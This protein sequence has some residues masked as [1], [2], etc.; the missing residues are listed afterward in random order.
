MKVAGRQT[1]RETVKVN[2]GAWVVP[3]AVT[4]KDFSALMELKGW[5][6]EFLAEQFKGKIEGP[7][8]FFQRMMVGKPNW[9]VI[10]PYRSVLV[11]YHEELAPFVREGKVRLCICGCGRRVYDRKDYASRSC[12][13]TGEGV[14]N[15]SGD[16][17]KGAVQGKSQK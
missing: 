8:K 6:P 14:T 17:K 7:L 13:R 2:D 1:N 16:A 15:L 5:T 11:S 12:P 10:I 4:F 3:L 9:D